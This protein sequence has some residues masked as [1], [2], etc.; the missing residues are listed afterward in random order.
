MEQ[1]QTGKR[2]IAL[3]ITLVILVF[4]LIGNVFL[5]SQFL[6]HKQ[7]NNFVTGQRIY[8]A[9]SESKKFI[10]EMILQL[11]AFMQSKE[12]DERLAL[13]F[14]AGKVYAQGQGLIDFAAEASNLSAESS[15]IDIALFSGYL[16]DMEAGLLAIGRND[17]LL[18]DEDQSYVASLK[19]TLGE[20]S[21]IMD[22]FNTNIDGNRNAI[23]R[24]S[25]GLDW[26]ELAE[27]LQQAI[28]SNAGQ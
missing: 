5:Y 23:I 4:S 21:V 18:S 28:N 8:E 9:G 6:Q 13:Y 2:S 15:G 10:S 12:L 16:K 24:L 7:E 26:I 1:Q 25:S 27:E 22:N 11:D 14:A 19:S 3:P 17:A 20:M